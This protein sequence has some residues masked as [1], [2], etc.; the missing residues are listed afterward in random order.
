MQKRKLLTKFRFT[1]ERINLNKWFAKSL[2]R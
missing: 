1:D 2:A